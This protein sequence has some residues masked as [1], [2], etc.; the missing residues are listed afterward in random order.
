MKFSDI[1]R[2]VVVSV[3]SPFLQFFCEYLIFAGTFMP[4]FMYSIPYSNC[5]SHTIFA[6][7]TI[8]HG[9]YVTMTSQHPSLSICLSLSFQ[10]FQSP[11]S[12]HL[13]RNIDRDYLPF[14]HS[15]QS[16]ISSRHELL[17]SRLKGNVMLLYG[18][19]FLFL[20][21]FSLS[22]SLLFTIFMIWIPYTISYFYIY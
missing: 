7:L 19:S 20:S 1:R 16:E 9:L 21:P 11:L 17:T 14:N 13:P 5:G 8:N 18:P 2:F 4:W 15:L 10:H 12:F 6:R 22:L 3:N